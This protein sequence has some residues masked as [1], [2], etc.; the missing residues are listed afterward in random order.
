MAYRGFIVWG[1]SAVVILGLF[2]GFVVGG[3]PGTANSCIPPTALALPVPSPH[4]SAAVQLQYQDKTVNQS[5]CYCEAFW[6]P[7]VVSGASGVRQPVNTWFNLYAIGTSFV[8]ALF[9]FFDRDKSSGGTAIRSHAWL[10]DLYIFVVLFLGLGSM[11]FHGALKEWG[12]ITDTLSMY[13]YT[14]FL[15][16]YSI[17][18][19]WDSDVFFVIGYVITVAAFT[20]LGE[21]WQQA[22][23]T[24]PVSL[25]MILILVGAYLTIEF[26]IWANAGSGTGLQNWWDHFSWFGQQASLLWWLAVACIGLATFFWISSQT[27]RYMCDPHSAF[28]PHGLLWHPLAGA[29]AVFLYFYWRREASA[30]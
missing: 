28:Q 27:G 14:A 15:V 26:V 6:L 4:A 5:T 20:I 21:L 19:L 7:D 13:M 2:L 23:P 11:W 9:V 18:R 24:F 10:P 3:W 12:G 1:G 22:M 17:Y 8:V 30:V 25:I 16:F 29:M